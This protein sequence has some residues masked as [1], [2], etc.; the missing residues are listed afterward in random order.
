MLFSS[1]GLTLSMNLVLELPV[2]HWKLYWQQDAE[3]YA[4]RSLF[5]PLIHMVWMF[6]T[7]VFT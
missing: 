7:P 1:T 2:P 5:K 6:G 3:L 4:G